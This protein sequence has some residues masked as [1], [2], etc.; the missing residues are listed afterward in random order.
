MASLSNA[1]L[2]RRLGV[3][4]EIARREVGRR[5]GLRE[6]AAV[7]AI[8]RLALAAAQID[9]RR[10]SSAWTLSGA[11]GEL[12]RRGDSPELQRADAA[13][14]AR[15]ARLAA[16]TPYMA[17]L[18]ERAGKFVGRP[19]PDPEAVS[20]ADLCAWALAAGAERIKSERV[21]GTANHVGKREVLA[22]GPR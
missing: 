2:R 16:R 11:E 17:D 9:P 5:Q 6:R 1:A 10:I 12:R 22:P 4:T 7:W 18:P 8:L 19:P 3:L 14:I 15:D 13:F 21:V 20:L